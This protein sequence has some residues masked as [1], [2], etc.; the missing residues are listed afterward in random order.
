MQSTLNKLSAIIVTITA[1][2]ITI[3]IVILITFGLFYIYLPL[4]SLLDKKVLLANNII[5]DSFLLSLLCN[6]PFMSKIYLPY[7]NK[8]CKVFRIFLFWVT[9]ISVLGFFSGLFPLLDFKKSITSNDFNDT[10]AVYLLMFCFISLI[11][12]FK[13]MF[14]EI[15][16]NELSSR[17]KIQLRFL[18]YSFALFLNILSVIKPSQDNNTFSIII[19]LGDKILATLIICDVLFSILFTEIK[20]V[21][22][23]LILLIIIYQY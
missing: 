12:F 5:L 20:K 6:L 13:N 8:A 19:G 17:S 9:I 11:L 2:I 22:L 4:V 10:K 7:K 15:Y 3:L 14:N 18:L 21:K 23:F 1:T 16:K